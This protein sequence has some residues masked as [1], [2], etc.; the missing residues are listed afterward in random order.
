MSRTVA[1]AIRDHVPSRRPLAHSHFCT[2]VWG[3]DGAPKYASG[4]EHNLTTDTA[5]G[6][7]NRRDWQSKAMG[8]GLGAFFGTNAAGAAT[9]TD[10]THLT[11]S[12]ATFPTA[13]QGLAGY[14]VAAGPN[15]SGA[16]STVFGYIVANTGTA[17]TVDQWYNPATGASGSTPNGTATYQILP[18]Q[19]PAMY[20]GVSADSGSPLSS[21]TVLAGPELSTNGF[22]R[23]LAVWAHTAAASTYTLQTTFTCSGGAGTVLN[24]EAVFGAANVAAGGVMPFESAVPSPPTLLSGDTCQITD[25]ISIG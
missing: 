13:S 10:A 2:E 1:D 24:K 8:G 3:A 25:S 18:G 14:I 22:T 20:I 15:S 5:V 19:A 12:G 17:L 23:R 6:Y 11:N 4:Y 16:G 7:T 9:S 21:D